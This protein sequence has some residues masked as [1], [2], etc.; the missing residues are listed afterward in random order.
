MKRLREALCTLGNGYFATRGAAEE[1]DADEIHYPGTYLAG[2]YKYASA[3]AGVAI[4]PQRRISAA[5]DVDS[6]TFYGGSRT[7]LSISRGKLNVSHQLSLEPTYSVNWLDL[8]QGSFTTQLASSLVLR[9]ADQHVVW[10]HDFGDRSYRDLSQTLRHDYFNNC[11]FC[12]PD[13]PP[14][15][16]TLVAEVTDVPTGKSAKRTLPLRVEPARRVAARG[17]AD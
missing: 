12:V 10:R 1:A 16:Y 8:P 13:V 7:T 5:F 14:G 2:G 9:D 4:G 17:A 15:Q 3:R 6:G 11:R